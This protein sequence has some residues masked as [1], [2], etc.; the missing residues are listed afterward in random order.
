MTATSTLSFPRRSVRWA[1]LNLGPVAQ[2]ALGAGTHTISVQ[3]ND[4]CTGTSETG[5]LAPQ[6]DTVALL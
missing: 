6:I 5:T 2:I 1:F 3:A 4:R